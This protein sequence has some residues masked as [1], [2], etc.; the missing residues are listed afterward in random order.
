MGV[1]GIVL[2]IIVTILIIWGIY[3]F[4]QKYN[5]EKNKNEISRNTDKLYDEKSLDIPCDSCR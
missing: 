1:L 2:I 5:T 4:I 3:Y